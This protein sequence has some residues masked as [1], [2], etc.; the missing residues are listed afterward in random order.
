MIDHR[1]LTR[2]EMKRLIEESDESETK[3]LKQALIDSNLDAYDFIAKLTKENDGLLSN[4]QPI[5]L[6]GLSHDNELWTVVN[7]EVKEQLSLY[8]N[9]KRVVEKWREKYGTITAT[10]EKT[11]PK[12]MRWVT[13]MGFKILSVDG[14]NVTFIL[15]GG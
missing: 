13:R 4:G 14:V 11:N 2:K 3:H 7:K 15:N 12:S 5:Y 1:Q 10:M 6:A 9:S 8:K